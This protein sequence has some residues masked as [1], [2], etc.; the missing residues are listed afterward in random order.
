MPTIDI[1]KIIIGFP[2]PTVD[3][4]IGLPSYDTIKDL[5]VQLNA[6]T[7]S[8]FN[9]LGYGQHDFLR[10]T[11]SDAQYNSVSAIPFVQSMNPGL[12]APSDLNAIASHIKQAIDKR[13]LQTEL[14]R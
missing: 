10:L 7:A 4:I 14:F 11:V 13:E 8:V 12:T 5:H 6:N 3:P 2:R 1:N 9:N